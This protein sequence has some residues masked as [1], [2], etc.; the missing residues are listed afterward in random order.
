M[1]NPAREITY[2]PL[3]TIQ[4]NPRNPKAHDTPT[5]DA[6]VSRFGFIEPIVIDGRTEQ[7]ISGHG[8]LKTLSA[9]HARNETP[10]EGIDLDKA[11]EWLV[12]VTTGWKSRTDTEA[13]GALI[14]LNRTTEIGGWVDDSLLGML[15]DLIE[16]DTN[17]LDGIG[18]DDDAIARL[19]EQVDMGEDLD[20]LADL[21]EQEADNQKQDLDV[22]KSG[23]VEV[24][25]SMSPEDRSRLLTGLRAAETALGTESRAETLVAV[26]HAAYGPDTGGE[27]TA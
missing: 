16:D 19:R 10:P 11:G 2:L 18:Y 24:K 4:P 12:P 7:I 9:M 17:G 27:E 1:T 14:A 8:R 20:F 15:E 21:T 6:S 25:F 23:Q 3:T 13:S 26:V 5:I 22:E